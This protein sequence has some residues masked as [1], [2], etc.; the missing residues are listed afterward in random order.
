MMD[1]DA[2]TNSSMAKPHAQNVQLLFM[3]ELSNIQQQQLSFSLKLEKE[4]KRK[5]YLDEHLEVANVQ[6]RKAQRDTRDGVIVKENDQLFR[7]QVALLEQK[8]EAT[9][10]KISVTR[11][12][13]Q[14]LRQKVM[15]LR[16]EKMMQ[17]EILNGL[18]I[19]LTNAKE[20]VEAAKRETVAVIDKKQRT[21]AAIANLKS[22]MVKEIQDFSHDLSAAKNSVYAAQDTMLTNIRSKLQSSMEWNLSHI[23]RTSAFHTGNVT[24]QG[25]EH[26]EKNNKKCSESG[27]SNHSHF[28]LNNLLAEVGVSSL[29]DLIIT[30]QKAEESMFT[31]Y[32]EMQERHLDVEKM[33][34]ENKKLEEQLFKAE[35]EVMSMEKNNEKMRTDLEDQIR[36]A[37]AIVAKSKDECEKSTEVLKTMSDCAMNLLRNIALEEEAL[38]VQILSTG[39][40]D[41]NVHQFLGLVEDRIDSLIQMKKATVRQD[42]HRDDFTLKTA[43]DERNV[44][45]DGKSALRAPNALPTLD[46]NPNAHDMNG[47]DDHRIMPLDIQKLKEQMARKSARAAKKTMNRSMSRGMSQISLMSSGSVASIASKA[48]QYSVHSANEKK[49]HAKNKKR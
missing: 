3:Q 13:N 11:V 1:V 12:N 41:R 9:K 2:I 10:V 47:D 18:N 25:S 45:F 8:L 5:E 16:K 29:E 27:S 24:N 14:A 44:L 48:S 4:K 20:K 42:L 33:E 21:Q 40:T 17:L 37:E 28:D 23:G 49:N 30:L 6:F 35:E 46:L 32:N 26:H 19:A 7:K 22:K 15:G 31:M 36:V 43:M 34:L 39:V 38:D